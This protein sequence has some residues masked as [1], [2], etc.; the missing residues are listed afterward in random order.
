MTT[1]YSNTSAPGQ[2]STNTTLLTTSELE[3]SLSKEFSPTGHF[4]DTAT[5][6]LPPETAISRLS[7]MVKAWQ[8]GVLNTPDFDQ[9]VTG[10]INHFANL[11]GVDPKTCAIVPQVSISS[12]MVAASLPEGSTVVLAEEDF[13]SVL[14]P[15][16]VQSDLGKLKLK[17]VPFD[18]VLESL[19]DEV[20]LVAVS[21]VQSADGRVIDLDALSEIANLHGI[22]TYLDLTQAAGWKRI[23]ASRFDVV[24]V[25]AYKW[26]CSPRGTGFLYASKTSSEWLKPFNAGWYA[27][28]DPWSSIYS[29]PL[30]LSSDG[31]KYN[32][33]P[34][35]FGYY[36]A[37]PTL[38]HLEEIG[39]DSIEAHN[40]YLANLLRSELGLS[41]SNSAIV[42]L[43]T[44]AP[45]EKFREANIQTSV[46]AGRTRITF[47]LY[48]DVEDVEAAAKVL[49]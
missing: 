43:T 42:S 4:L 1:D 12:A 3:R 35:W 39:I 18:R 7:E 29:S 16:F 45:L 32:I 6:G 46:R 30:R 5:I 23:E 10:S 17:V 20:D 11:V 21:A 25:S 33:S 40:V 27:G 34:D 14:F 9:S 22:K 44:D 49:S 13:T 38:A 36:A 41:D 26:L 37:E 47:H 28:E 2:R 15:F 48:N 8:G 31:R 19:T 24:S